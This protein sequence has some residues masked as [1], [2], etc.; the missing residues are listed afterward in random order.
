MQTPDKVAA[1]NNSPAGQVARCNGS[2]ASPFAGRAPTTPT[3]G[4]GSCAFFTVWNVRL[5]ESLRRRIIC[6]DAIG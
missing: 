4:C 5:D 1:D 6:R 2:F 3:S